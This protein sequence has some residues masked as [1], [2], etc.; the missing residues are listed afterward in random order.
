MTQ[1][2]PVQ[3][4]VNTALYTV[5]MQQF[6][7]LTAAV[8]RVKRRIM[9][10]TENLLR[11]CGSAELQ[12]CLEPQQLALEDLLVVRVGEVLLKGPAACAAQ[13]GLFI[14]KTVIMQ[15]INGSKS[16]FI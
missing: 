6:D 9:Q 15:K 5:L 4:S 14:E 1:A 10:E 11:I 3:M 8:G 2:F 16:V 7:D 13:R 12:R